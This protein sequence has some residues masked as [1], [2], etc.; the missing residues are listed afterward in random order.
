MD[1]VLSLQGKV[2]TVEQPGESPQT[3]QLAGIAPASERWQAEANGVI[4]ML[5]ESNQGQVS[6]ELLSQTPFGTRLAVI[7]LPNG[8]TLQEILLE[9]GVAKLDSDSL[10]TLPPEVVTTLKQAQASAQLQHKN[11]WSP[12]AAQ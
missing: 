11:I 12:E 5:L 8:T 9:D 4:A 7:E 1:Q 2:L 10:K 3:V 6:V